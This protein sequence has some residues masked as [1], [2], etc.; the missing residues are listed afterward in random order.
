MSCGLGM[1]IQRPVPLVSGLSLAGSS[2]L[3]RTGVTGYDCVL[4]RGSRLAGPKLV[5]IFRGSLPGCLW[6]SGM[7]N[8]VQ[9]SEASSAEK[10]ILE[11]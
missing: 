7:T 6:L 10:A 8:P 11:N 4:Y 2:P 5:S 1:L 3:V 9:H